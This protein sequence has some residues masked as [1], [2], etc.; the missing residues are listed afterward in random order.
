MLNPE[1]LA[2]LR[3]GM[4]QVPE[5]GGEPGLFEERL[6]QW[7]VEQSFFR[8]F[9]YRN[10][11][12]KKKGD[13]LV[14]AIVLFGDVMLLVEVKAQIGSAQRDDWVRDRL[15][16]A[17]SQ[18][19]K[20]YRILKD[21]KI[22]KL[23]NDF[24]GELDFD[25]DRYPNVFGIVIL[26]HNSEPYEAAS[27]VPELS[28]S[29]FPMHVFTLDDFRLIASRFDT[30]GDM[31]TFLELRTDIANLVRLYV[32][33]ES[34]N[35]QHM[36][37]QMR[38]VLGRYLS[39]NSPET[40]DKSYSSFTKKATGELLQSPDW[41]YGLVID[42]IIA[43]AHD[44]DPDLPWNQHGPDT[45]ALEVSK[46]LGWL[47][48]D[49]RI[50]LGKKALEHCDLAKDGN[51]YYF[52]HFHPSRGTVFVFRASSESRHDRVAYL[53]YLVSYAQM[54]HGASSGLG[55]ATE[56]IGDGRSYDFIVAHT[57]PP[58]EI[59][60]SIKRFGDPFSDNLKPL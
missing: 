29:P 32:Q 3:F 23:V 28:A 25:P 24:Y 30:A 58:V 15:T 11:K 17:V 22:S 42:D 53:Q 55:V 2:S 60:E 54:K 37:P 20:T 6:A 9:V 12:G 38:A 35:I 45:A 13:Q 36:L 40:L 56:P 52:Y 5:L 4:S 34:G 51:D 19:E 33:D 49:R 59:I 39:T 48:R 57:Y 46:F 21:R 43:R 8:D 47:T 14:D 1:Q 50:N 31:I 18:I 41:K 10:A 26:A 44:V 7:L 27:L 16:K